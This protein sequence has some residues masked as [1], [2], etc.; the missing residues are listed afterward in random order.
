MKLAYD[1]WVLLSSSRI[2]PNHKT[3]LLI[4]LLLSF[5]FLHDLWNSKEFSMGVDDISWFINNTIHAQNEHDFWYHILHYNAN[6]IEVY[7]L[8]CSTYLVYILKTP[9]NSVKICFSLYPKKVEMTNLG[10]L[11]MDLVVY[12]V[13]ILVCS[14]DW[15]ILRNK[16]TTMKNH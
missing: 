16:S 5:S 12:F 1:K 13:I 11:G 8:V 3:R 6:V 9:K 2:R 10:N 14:I 7:H 15:H 4:F